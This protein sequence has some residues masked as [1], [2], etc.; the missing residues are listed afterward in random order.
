MAA[1]SIP[2]GALK[3]IDGVLH[4]R[5]CD[6]WYPVEG[7]PAPEDWS[8][9]GDEDLIDPPPD[10]YDEADACAKVLAYTS[11]VFSVIDRL[12]TD[13]DSVELPHN[14]LRHVYEDHPDIDFGDLDLLNAYMAALNVNVQGFADTAKDTDTRQNIICRMEPYVSDGDAGLTSDEYSDI[15]SASSSY[16]SSVWTIAA[17]PTIFG[18]LQAL[19]IYANSSIGPND[20]RKQTTYAGQ[21]LPEACW[22]T[23]QEE[24]YEG[25]VFFNGVLMTAEH[26]DWVSRYEVK[27]NGRAVEIDWTSP[28]GD[29]LANYVRHGLNW[30]APVESFLVRTT[31]LPGSAVPHNEWYDAPDCG[32][33]T[34]WG[35]PLRNA[36][37]WTTTHDWSVPDQADSLLESSNPGGSTF[38]D[39]LD[40]PMRQCQE[41]D[42]ISEQFSVRLEIIEVNGEVV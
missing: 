40:H 15:K 12:L 27:D 23:G 18:N 39:G 1:C 26:Y 13:A 14:A 24:E 38:T 28:G 17:Y 5:Y 19:Y 16:L 7:A 42:P 21:S 10:T 20:A 33:L 3:Y 9:P 2:Y 32:V 22:C 37:T 35:I 41:G 36:G 4:Y 29:F 8:D 6:E 11:V 34:N 31:L 25:D 30:I